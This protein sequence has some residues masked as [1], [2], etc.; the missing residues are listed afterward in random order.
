MI[1]WWQS[2]SK[3]VNCVNY[4]FP[5]YMDWPNAG[6]IWNGPKPISNKKGG[7]PPFLLSVFFGPFHIYRRSASDRRGWKA[8][9]RMTIAGLMVWGYFAYKLVSER[10]FQKGGFQV[11]GFRQV[12]GTILGECQKWLRNAPPII[13]WQG[14]TPAIFFGGSIPPGEGEGI[15]SANVGHE[16]LA[17]ILEGRPLT[18]EVKISQSWHFS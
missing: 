15:T 7:L 10:G 12:C 6:N 4:W 5:K 17:Q 9:I 3:N 14:G 8:S 16:I 2:C 13:C 11:D 18:L 1:I